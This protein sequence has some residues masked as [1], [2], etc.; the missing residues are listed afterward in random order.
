MVGSF[1]EKLTAFL[2]RISASLE[3]RIALKSYRNL[4]AKV[5]KEE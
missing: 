5:K 4:L 2:S 3:A 1:K